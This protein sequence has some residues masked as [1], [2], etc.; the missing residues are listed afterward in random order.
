MNLLGLFGKRVTGLTGADQRLFL[1]VFT[2]FSNT[3][4]EVGKRL[5][6]HDS[7]IAD[8]RQQVESLRSELAAIKREP[9]KPFAQKLRE[10]GKP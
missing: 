4:E 7:E 5:R 9:H 6:E 8:L 2:D 3:F 10:K 1:S